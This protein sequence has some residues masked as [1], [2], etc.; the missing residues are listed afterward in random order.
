MSV[1]LENGF[2]KVANELFEIIPFYKFNGSQFSIIITVLRFTYGF[3]RKD[4]DISITFLTNATG[5]KRTQVDRELNT[6]LENK[7][8]NV[9]KESTKTEARKLSLNKHYEQWLIPRRYPLIRGQC[10]KKSIPEI[11]DTVSPNQGTEGIPYLGDKEIQSSFKENATTTENAMIR[12]LNAY[13]KIHNKLDI[14]IKPKER[15]AM[16]QLSKS[17][18]PTEFVIDCMDKMC[19]KKIDEGEK[20][21]TFLYYPD[22][23]KDAW[24]RNTTVVEFKP[25]KVS[26]EEIFRKFLEGS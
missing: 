22:A 13:C 23:I 11:E 10:P 21:S 5:I 16:D 9:T 12:I 2:T 26:E 24:S 8:I 7:V 15:S 14:N 1:Q 3:N 19:R 25:K 4:H 20:I 17:G 18:I 6:L